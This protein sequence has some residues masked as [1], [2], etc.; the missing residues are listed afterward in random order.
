MRLPWRF[1]PRRTA[2]LTPELAR[3]RDDLLDQGFEVVADVYDRRSFGNMSVVLEDGTL[4]AAIVR[5]RGNWEVSVGWPGPGPR[6]DRAR[7]QSFFDAKL[8]RMGDTTLADDCAFFLAHMNDIR[9][10]IRDRPEETAAG[11]DFWSTKMF[12]EWLPHRPSG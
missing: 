11:L 8:V 4:G 10:A 9:S 12:E 5:D 1:R 6:A 2:K 7:W 3:F